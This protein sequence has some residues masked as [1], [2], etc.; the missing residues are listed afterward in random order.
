MG[1]PEEGET[2]AGD[3][4]GQATTAAAT[5]EEW[6]QQQANEADRE[7]RHCGHKAH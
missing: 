2:A 6:Q 4:G 3:D 1:L 5:H 7:A